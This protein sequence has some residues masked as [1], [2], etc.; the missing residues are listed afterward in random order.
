VTITY[1][2]AGG[3]T[4]PADCAFACNTD[5][6]LIG[7]ACVNSR[8][9][10]CA[11]ITPPANAHQV[12]SQVTITYTT[13]SG[14]TDPANCAW[15]CNTDYDLF[16]GACIN[17]RLVA[18][19]PITPPANASQVDGQVTI[20]YTTAS[21]WTD[22]A[23]CGWACNEGFHREDDAC[24]QNVEILWCNT[25]WPRPGYSRTAG[26]T[27]TIYGQV[28]ALDTELTGQRPG[29]MGQLCTSDATP[30]FPVDLSSMDCVDATFSGDINNNDEYR[31]DLTFDLPGTYYYLYIFSGDGGDTWTVCDT[32]GPVTSDPVV[33]GVADITGCVVSGWTLQQANS[34]VNWVIPAG[35]II[36][37]GSMLIVGRNADKAAFE[38]FWGVSLGEDVLYIDSADKIPLINGAETYT[39]LDD[40]MAIIDGPTIGMTVGQSIQRTSSGAADDEASWSR[41]SYTT[42]TPG[43]SLLPL[44][45]AGVLISEFSDATGTGNYVYEFVEIYCDNP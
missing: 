1:T 24:V 6:D 33:P 2:T 3:W 44:S 10:D 37:K 43:S 18:C 13:A 8:L 4:S 40:S 28:W 21:G 23:D 29:I 39:L 14:W 12:E 45:G 30:T 22:P 36:P 5:Y 19:A 25:Q 38:A 20:T 17:S 42:A 26:L 41:A 16:G 35:T 27:E 7:G 9:V 15:A 34:A 11:D 32:D 31:Q